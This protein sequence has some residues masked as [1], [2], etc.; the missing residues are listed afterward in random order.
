[1]RATTDFVIGGH[2]LDSRYQF[3]E[4]RDLALLRDYR[5]LVADRLVRRVAVFG[6]SGQYLTNIGRPGEGPGEFGNFAR[7]VAVSPTEEVWLEVGYGYVVFSPDLQG[8]TYD[9]TVRAGFRRPVRGKA[10]FGP[11]GLV[12]LRLPGIH[13]AIAWLS[14]GRVVREEPLPSVIPWDE[15]GYGELFATTRDGRQIRQEVRGPFHARDLLRHGRS[16]GYAR[17]VTSRY[18][19]QMFDPDGMHITTIRRQ[20]QGPAVSMTER[21]RESHMLDSLIAFHARRGWRYPEFQVPVRK[22]PIN[23]L[24]FDE[25]DRL[26]VNL[27]LAD[28]VPLASA[29]V[30]TRQGSFLFTATWPR[31][32]S[33][34]HG[35]IRDRVAIGVRTGDLDVPEIVR[36]TFVPRQPTGVRL[37]PTAPQGG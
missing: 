4:V 15:L 25:E 36:M 22:P 35:A 12:G 16:G 32:V 14:D 20:I 31:D 33:L 7:S 29:H 2:T 19:I 18:E 28:T 13:G 37:S 8:W 26:W 24:W 11:H 21:R 34:E 6:E 9:R 3:G 5:F 30:Y 27:S 10:M 23:D 1:M 17:A